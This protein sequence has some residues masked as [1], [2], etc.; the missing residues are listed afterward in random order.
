[1]LTLHDM[2]ATLITAEEVQNSTF[3]IPEWSFLA[4]F[5]ITENYDPSWLWHA[6]SHDQPILSCANF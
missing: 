4:E 1:M 5:R 6:G 2:Q 3:S